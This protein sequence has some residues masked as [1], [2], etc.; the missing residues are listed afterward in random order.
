[1]EFDHDSSRYGESIAKIYDEW[2]SDLASD[3]AATVEFL[4]QRAAGRRVLELG[5]GTGRIGLPLAARGVQVAGIEIS[6]AMI[7]QLRAKPGGKAIHVTI[8]DMVDVQGGPFDLVFA[9]YN[10]MMFILSQDD[11]VRCFQ[12]VARRLTPAGVFVIENWIPSD[13]EAV[14]SAHRTKTT[15]LSK[16]RVLLDVE[17][18]DQT[19]QHIRGRSV[20][21]GA[22]GIEVYA[23][24]VRY[25]WPTE[26]DLMARLANM[27]L[28]ERWGGWR[29]EPYTSTSR[30][31]VSVY[32]LVPTN[33][34]TG[35][36]H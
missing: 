9:V 14:R 26:L 6:P 31:H 35:T 18:W 13:S 28:R 21:I 10:T 23:Y 3:P 33:A 36:G 24:G 25:I 17:D 34:S 11:Q 19:L 22:A 16:E 7:A 20:V 32:E 8:G 4:F 15:I 27:R 30:N 5:I 1:M 2:E 12:N 29:N